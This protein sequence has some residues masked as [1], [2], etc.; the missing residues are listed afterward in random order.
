[1]RYNQQHFFFF[2]SSP[3]FPALFRFTVPP[4]DFIG[5]LL[6]TGLLF[7]SCFFVWGYYLVFLPP[8]IT[9][10]SSRKNYLTLWPVFAETYMYVRPSSLILDD[11]ILFSTD[12]SASRSHLLP[13]III[14]ASSPRTYRTLSIHLFKLPKE[15]ASKLTI[16]NT[17]NVKDNNCCTWIFNIGWNK[18]V[19]SFLPCSIPQL[20]P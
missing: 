9:N 14:K 11:A 1:M 7:V 20:H 18:R 8:A 4:L 10:A 3:I 16:R 12:L 15:L 13:I 6:A 19:K 2:F 5:W 17:R